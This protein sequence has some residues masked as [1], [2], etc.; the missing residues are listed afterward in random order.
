[1][2]DLEP[3]V[4]C[5]IQ[6]RFLSSRLVGK[7]LKKLSGF[8]V[9]ELCVRR[10]QRCNDIDKIVVLTGD[11]S[12]NLQIVAECTR[13]GVTCFQGP[14]EDVLGRFLLAHK[15]YNSDIIIRITADC[16][17]VDPYLISRGITKFKTGDYEYISNTLPPSFPDGL[18]FEIFSAEALN[19]ISTIA[20]NTYDR[21]HVTPLLRSGAVFSK[22]NIVG[23][24]DNSDIRWTLDGS[25]DYEL[26]Q[27]LVS[28]V[29]DP[30]NSSY[31]EYLN[32]YFQLGLEKHRSQITVR[33]DG[34]M[35][36]KSKK[37]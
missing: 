19:K 32:A 4:I 10:L 12:E 29:Q 5:F 36:S 25:E 23:E 27:I 2:V 15:T 26:L 22:F 28:H 3:Y 1:M 31:D 35:Q 24:K 13:I 14:E 20:I 8:S 16:P 9:L 34:A 37:L 18:D 33:N 17:L 7:V 6:A 11:I 21:E 30:I